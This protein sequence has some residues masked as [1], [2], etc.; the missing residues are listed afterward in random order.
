MRVGFCL[1]AANGIDNTQRTQIHYVVKENA[2]EWWHEFL[3]LWIVRGKLT[4]SEW[5]DLFKVIL[6]EPPAG[7]LVLRLP[8]TPPRSW[9]A[10]RVGGLNWFRENYFEWSEQE[11]E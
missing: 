9:A 6:P 2:D 3:D 1:I 4:P 5:R 8:D 11:D 10:R 7:A